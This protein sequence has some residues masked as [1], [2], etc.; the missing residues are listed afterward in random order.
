LQTSKKDVTKK[1]LLCNKLNQLK[2]GEEIGVEGYF[3]EVR[4]LLSQLG[5]IKVIIDNDNL[6]Q[7]VLNVLPDNYDPFI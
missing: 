2:M 4:T 1:L 3:K 6:I 7:I 5:G